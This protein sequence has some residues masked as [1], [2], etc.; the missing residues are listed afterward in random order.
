MKSLRHFI[1]HHRGLVLCLET[2]PSLLSRCAEPFSHCLIKIFLGCYVF[3]LFLFVY[4][5]SLFLL[6]I[7]CIT[8]NYYPSLSWPGKLEILLSEK[9]TTLHSHFSTPL[10]VP[11][12]FLVD[13]FFSFISPK[14]SLILCFQICFNALQSLH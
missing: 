10:T 7:R 13:P 11:S 12:M 14:G 9:L 1:P 4:S 3:P 8:L 6:Q 5:S 2:A